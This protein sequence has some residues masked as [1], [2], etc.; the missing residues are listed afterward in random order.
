MRLLG[1]ITSLRLLF[2]KGFLFLFAGLLASVLLLVEA[3]EWKVLLLHALAIWCFCRFYYFAFYVIQHYADPGYR[4]AGLGSFVYYLWQRRRAS[5]S[6]PPT[7]PEEP[8]A[9]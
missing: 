2:A 6:K 8:P 1:D 7:P 9:G 4:F 3:P 5:P